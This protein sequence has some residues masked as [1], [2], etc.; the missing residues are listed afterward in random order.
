MQTA[1]SFPCDGSRVIER[2]FTALDGCGNSATYV[3]TISSF[4]TTAPTF[5][6]TPEDLSLECSEALPTTSAEAIG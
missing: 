2:T 3:Q 6:V 5:T 1:E 4:D